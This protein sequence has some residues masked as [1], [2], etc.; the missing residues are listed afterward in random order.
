MKNNL[1]EK[2]LIDFDKL[3]IPF[4]KAKHKDEIHAFLSNEIPKLVQEAVGKD[5]VWGGYN[6]E[7]VVDD[8]VALG[9]NELRWEILKK[10]GIKI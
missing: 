4:F 5:E 3:R 1:T 7:G 8:K 10:F 9:R 2:L 6:E